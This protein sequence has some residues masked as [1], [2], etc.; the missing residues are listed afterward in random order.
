MSDWTEAT[1]SR[2]GITHFEWLQAEKARVRSLLSKQASPAAL[3]R[4]PKPIIPKRETLPPV[5]LA[6]RR[7]AINARQQAISRAVSRAR[8]LGT[9]AT[10]EQER[11]ILASPF[12]RIQAT[13]GGGAHLKELA[14]VAGAALGLSP[15]DLARQRSSVRYTYGRYVVAL[16]L[17]DLCMVSSERIGE[18]LGVSFENAKNARRRGRNL[19]A[20][21]PAYTEKYGVALQAVYARWPQYRTA[22]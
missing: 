12:Y 5:V 3:A 1:D 11:A 13:E 16:V 19:L 2:E 4:L 10:P 9:F 15:D 17:A 22:A 8:V 20:R 21:S 18:A 14:A 6:T 7:D